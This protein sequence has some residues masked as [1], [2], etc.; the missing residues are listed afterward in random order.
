[1]TDYIVCWLRAYPNSYFLEVLPEIS[2]RIADGLEVYD[3]ARDNFALLVGEE[4]LDNLGRSQKSMRDIQKHSAFGRKRD[5]LPE[6]LLQR[7]EYASKK[8]IDRILQDF[9]SLVGKDMQWVEELSEVQ[10]LS[11]HTQPE[12]QPVIQSLKH[13]LKEYLRGS[14]YKMLCA[15]YDQVP[16]AHFPNGGGGGALFQHWKRNFVWNDLSPRERVLTRTFW[17]CLRGAVSFGEGSSNLDLALDWAFTFHSSSFSLAENRVMDTHRYREIPTQHVRQLIAKGQLWLAQNT[18]PSSQLPDMPHAEKST[19]MAD[20]QHQSVDFLNTQPS[21]ISLPFRPQPKARHSGS[22]DLDATTPPVSYISTSQHQG[23]RSQPI[24][25][26]KQS[27]PEQGKLNG[28]VREQPE[29]SDSNEPMLKSSSISAWKNFTMKLPNVTIEEG[30]LGAQKSQRENALKPLTVSPP[31]PNDNLYLEAAQKV[32]RRKATKHHW[33]KDV[34]KSAFEGT[35]NRSRG[36]AVNDQQDLPRFAFGEKFNPTPDEACGFTVGGIPVHNSSSLQTFFRLRTFFKQAQTYIDTIADRKLSSPDQN[37]R[38]DPIDL[39]LANTLVC[40]EDSEFE[41]LP[42]WAGG[43]DDGTGG[44]YQAE[45]PQSEMEFSTAGPH[46]HTGTSDYS[47]SGF[48]LVS[49]ESSSTFN[50]STATNDGFSSHMRPNRVYAASSAASSSVGDDFSMVDSPPDKDEEAF[51]RRQIEA[52]EL[53][54]AAEAEAAENRR[55]FR[56]R[57]ST[58]ENYADLFQGGPDDDSDGGYSSEETEMGDDLSDVGRIS[59]LSEEHEDD[60]T[61]MV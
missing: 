30:G 18:V 59:D 37:T 23:T 43:L 57:F 17:K 49:A 16:E 53:I 15:N 8:F 60:D 26:P 61:V 28:Q 50:T 45:I 39:G 52:M 22:K 24:R 48:D 1:L 14:I 58:D 9:E 32:V 31:R 6:L 21:N 40:L 12:L 4:A 46:I 25:I 2:F 44:V 54:E 7:V 42:L 47:D 19:E 5:D 13:L 11:S 34:A 35:F 38:Q 36:F 3:L 20:K 41:Y 56:G 29:K 10:Q 27:A 33:G 51:A 55:P